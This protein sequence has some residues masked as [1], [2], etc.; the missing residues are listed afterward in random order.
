MGFSLVTWNAAESRSTLRAFSPDADESVMT[1][2]GDRLP[3][4]CLTLTGHAMRLSLIIGEQPC[5]KHIQTSDR[6]PFAPSDC[7]TIFGDIRPQISGTSLTRVLALSETNSDNDKGLTIDQHRDH[8]EVDQSARDLH[9]LDFII[10]PPLQHWLEK[11]GL[12]GGT[13]VT[14]SRVWFDLH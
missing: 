6:K 5:H 10:S 12:V 1:S 7:F 9:L 14:P 4:A 8:K 3:E 2:D 11:V 13:E